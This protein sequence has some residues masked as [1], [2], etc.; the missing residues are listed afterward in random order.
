MA[1]KEQIDRLKEAEKVQN[2][3]RGVC[4]VK[5]I[6][7]ML[8]KGRDADA[9]ATCRGENDKIRSYP[10]VQAVLYEI[11]PEYKED[12]DRLTRLFGW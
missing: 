3:G 9:L 8:E 4:C 11:F 5:D 10:P 7:K 12:W 2:Q 6:I 1:T